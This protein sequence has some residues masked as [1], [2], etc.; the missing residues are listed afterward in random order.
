M[1]QIKSSSAG[2]WSKLPTQQTQDQQSGERWLCGA[3]RHTGNKVALHNS[4]A[5][6]GGIRGTQCTIWTLLQLIKAVQ[7]G[8]TLGPFMLLVS[9]LSWT[10]NY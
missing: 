3:T 5:W 4:S 1:L 9:L 10:V 2:N 7:E 6:I 8:G